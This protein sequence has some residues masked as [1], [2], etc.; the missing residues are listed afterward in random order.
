MIALWLVSV[1]HAACTVISGAE[2]YLPVGLEKGMTVVTVDDRIAAVGRGLPDLRVEL[3]AVQRARGA[4]YRGESCRFVQAG[5][6]RLTAGF[7]A[8]PVQIG[9]VEVSLESRTRDD[10]AETDDDIRASLRVVDAYD[11]RSPLVRVNRA[12]GLT[13][14]V[15]VPSGAFVPGF[16]GFVKL[17]GSTQAEAVRARE[18]ALPVEQWS[19][20]FAAHVQQLREL[21]EDARRYGRSRNSYEARVPYLEGMSRLDLQALQSVVNRRVPVLLPADRASDI[22]ALIRLKTELGLRVVI[23][24]GAEAWRH[25]KALSQAEIPVVVDPLVYGPGSFDQREARPDNAAILARAGVDVILTPGFGEAHNVRV[26]RQIA[27]NAVRGGM[28]PN[29]AIA[30][31]SEVPA[32]VFGQPLLGRIDSGATA[33]LALWSGDPLE[34]STSLEELWVDGKSVDLRTRQSEL[35]RKYLELPGTPAEP[36]T[37]P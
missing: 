31:I 34:L 29:D 27:G 6:K 25:A 5:G 8:M 23:L 3:D 26:L 9:L 28:T 19:G 37:L 17:D 15:V 20:S 14:A 18:A 33:D 12:E 4:S 13:S 21:V 10:D 32:R 11:P 36:L 7:V 30:S 24:G 35:A 16:A 22:E 2:A 1:A